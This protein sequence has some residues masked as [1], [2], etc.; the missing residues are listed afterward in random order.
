MGSKNTVQGIELLRLALMFMI[1]LEH[2][3]GH[4]L[5][6]LDYINNQ[7]NSPT[8]YQWLLYT[9]C[10]MAVNCF[11]FISGY[12]G[13]IYS[14][15]K[16]YKLVIQAVSTIVILLFFA[17]GIFPILG[18][19][20]S[21]RLLDIV[22]MCIPIT[23]NYW[24]FLSLYIVLLLLS[25]FLNNY[26][27]FDKKDRWSILFL[28]FMINCFGG[29]LFN[30][31]GANLGYSLLNF[32]F[33]YLLGRELQMSPKFLKHDNIYLLVYILS[34]I[35]LYVIVYITKDMGPTVMKRV[36]AYNNPL[37]LLNAI[38]FFRFFITL[39]LNI[40]IKSISIYSFG[41]Y[42]LHDNPIVRPFLTDFC[43]GK[44][45]IPVTIFIF[46]VCLLVEAFRYNTLKIVQRL[47]TI[48][49]IGK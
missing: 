30:T 17:F 23:F 43:Y 45:I 19:S 28:L 21:M 3:I 37:I 6:L 31:A 42:L 16:V 47:F 46:I 11:V 22:S 32:I 27:K 34:L 1:V 9:P 4:G 33:V 18:F 8:I 39:K 14:N 49:G 48:S 20:V 7:T 24:W 10:V 38:L 29:L 5:G 25:S 15:Q 35:V 13:M 12:F 44:R 26:V 40:N 36:F 41:I 2:I